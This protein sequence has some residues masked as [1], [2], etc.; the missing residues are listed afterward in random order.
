MQTSFVIYTAPGPVE[1]FFTF[2]LGLRTVDAFAEEFG[3][4]AVN[5]T[6]G[7]FALFSGTPSGGA[8][9]GAWNPFTNVGT[10]TVYSS[11]GAG[12]YY[13]EVTGTVN[14]KDAA[15]DFEAFASRPAI[16]EPTNVALLLAGFGIVEIHGTS[17]PHLTGRRPIRKEPR[18]AGFFLP[19]VLGRASSVECADHDVVALRIPERELPSPGGRIRRGF[20]L[21]SFDEGP[22]A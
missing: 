22:G 19:S 7:E 16:P 9:I 15:Y 1:D 11:L 14:A 8:Q 3:A 5:L 10:E 12:N 2:S 21:E 17:T 18:S 13:F 4:R 6:N 20:L